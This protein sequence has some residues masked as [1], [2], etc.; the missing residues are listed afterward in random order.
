MI[1][2]IE[3]SFWSDAL[4]AF[5][6]DYRI[7]APALRQNP[8]FRDG[9]MTTLNHSIWFSPEAA[10][11]LENENDWFLYDTHSIMS[12][13]NTVLCEGFLWNEKKELLAI[14]KQQGLCRPKL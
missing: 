7:M 3:H 2:D 1:K 10:C 4:L 14:T 8:D 11:K 13:N 6:S 9:K 5:A 12:G